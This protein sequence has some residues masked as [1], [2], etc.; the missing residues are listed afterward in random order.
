MGKGYIFTTTQRRF[1]RVALLLIALL[2]APGMGWGQTLS[3]YTFSASSGTFSALG[4]GSTQLTGGDDEVSNS[5]PIGFTF[6]YCGVDYTSVSASTNGWMTFGQNITD[7]A[8]NN[9]LASRGTRPVIA[10]LWDDLDMTSGTMNSA[11]TGVYPNRVFTLEWYGAEWNWKANSQVISFQVKLYETSGKIEFIYKREAAAVNSGTASIGITNGS[12]GNGNFI[13]LQDVS[14][15]PT[16]STTN[17]IT[18]ISTRPVTGQV[19]AFVPPV[20]FSQGSG[21]PNVL[22]NWKT[23]GGLSPTSFTLPNQIF[24]VQPGH[25]MTTTAAGWSVSGANTKVQVQGGGV[26]TATSGAVTLSGNTTFQLDANATYNHNVASDAIWSGTEVLDAASTVVYGASGAQNVAALNYGNLTI[27]G[28]G[29]KTMQGSVTVNGTLNLSNGSISLGSGTN[30]LTI[31]DGATL[32]GSFDSNHMVICDG[33]GSL[34]KQ[35]NSAADFVMV[36]PVGTGAYYTPY[37]ITSLTATATATSSVAVRAVASK[38]TGANDTDLTKYWAVAT[39]GL[40]GIAANV[41]MAYNNSEVGAGGDQA[42][43]IP[44]YYNGTT[45][46]VPTTASGPGAN[47]M[48]VTGAT[49]LTG[50]WTAREQPKYTTYY[51]YQSGDWNVATTWTTDPSGTLS[52]APAIPTPNDRVVILNG[53]TVATTENN[54]N[55]LSVQVNEGGTLDLGNFTTQSFTVVRGQGLVRLSNS[56]FP[57]A[58]WSSFV[59]AGGGTVE[60]YNSADFNFGQLIY[61]NLILNLSANTN[62]ATLVGNMTVN[63]NLTV[64]RGKLQINSN[65]STTSRNLTVMGNVYVSANGSIGIGTGNAKHRIEV[66]GNFTNDGVVRFTNQAAPQYTATPANGRSDVVFNNATADQSLLCNGQSDFY[67][68]EIDKG[69]D[70][71]YVLNIDASASANFKLFGRNDQ[72]HYL[73]SETPPNLPN[74]NALGLLAGTVRLGNNVLIPCLGTDNWDGDHGVY[75]IDEDARLWLDGATVIWNANNQN[76]TPVVYGTLRISEN[77]YFDIKNGTNGLVMR[78]TG[79]LSV[80]GGQLDITSLRV[81]SQDGLGA[82]RGAYY[83]TGGTVNVTGGKTDFAASFMLPYSAMAF[84]MSGGTI[85]IL[86]PSSA[87]G[88]GRNFSLIIGANPSNINVTGGTIN[89]TTPTGGQGNINSSAP[90]WDLNIQGAGTAY[91][92]DYLQNGSLPYV[93]AITAPSLIVL[94]NLSLNGSSTLNTNSKDVLIGGDFLL[95]TGTYYLSGSNTTTFNGLSGQRFTNLGTVGTGGNGLYNLTVAGKSNLDIYSNNL[96]VRNNLT[97]DSGCFLNDVGHTIS[98]NGNVTNSGTHTSQAS[99]AILLNGTANQIVGGDGNGIFGNLNLNNGAGAKLTANQSVEGNL[100]L[101]AGVLDIGSYNLKLGSASNVYDALTGTTTASFG[102]AK[103]IKLAGLQSD[104]GVTKAYS[105]TANFLYPIG[106]ASDYTPANIRIGTAPAAWGAVTVRPVAQIQPF[107]TSTNALTYYWKVTSSGFGGLQPSS[108]THSYQ[109]VDADATNGVEASYIPAA[110]RPY[111]W[112]PINDPSKVVDNTNTINFSGISYVDGDYTAGEPN[113]FMPVKVFYSRVDEGEW[114]NSDTWSTD[115]VGGA[116]VATGSVEGVNI[117]GPNNPVVIGDATHNH[118]VT[119]PVGYKT[120]TTGGLQIS[121]GSTL[122]LTTTTGHNFGAIPDSKVLGTGTL[123][124]SSSAATAEFPGG[125]FGNFLSSGGGTVEYYSTSTLGSSF[126]LPTTYVSAGTTVNIA[127]YNNLVT[128]PAG[129]NTVTL[130]N[131]E[132]LVYGTYSAGGA[133]VSQLNSTATSR[134]LTVNTLLEVKASG[135][136]R[137]VNGGVQNVVANGNVVVDGTFDVNNGGSA[138]N[139]MTIQGNLTNNGTFDMYKS[140]T[141]LCDVTFTGDTDKEIN[142]TGT[143]TNFN[144][145][146]VNKGTSRN[147]LLE[148]K[149]AALSLNTSLPTALTLTSGTFRLTSP[150]T[151][152]LTNSGSFTIPISGCL[153]ANGG[154]I[155]IGGTAADDATDLKLDGRLEVLAGAVNIGTLGNNLNNDIEYS[156]GGTPEIIVGGT[157]KLFVNG[158]IRRVTTINTGSLNYSQSGSSEVTIAGRNANNSRSML[159]ILNAGSKFDMSGDSKL[160]ITG[161][162]NSSSSPDLYLAPENSTVTGGTVVLGSG[163]SAANSTFNIVTSVPLWNLTVDGTTSSKKGALNI[164]PLVLK[165]DLTINGNSS[166]MANGLDVTIAGGLINKNGNAATGVTTGGYQAGSLTQ[167]TTFNGTNQSISGNG[168]NLTNFANLIVAPSGTLTLNPNSN[169]R[170][171]GNLS[172]NSGVLSDG[173]NSITQIGNVYS[174]AKHVSP[175]GDG[176]ISF[177]GGQPQV[178]SGNGAAIFGNVI[179]NNSLGLVIRDNFGIDGKL[180]F[181]TGSIYLDDYLLTLGKD[182]TIAGT[183]DSSRMIILN[184]VI[185]DAGVKK[186]FNAGASTFT[187]PFGVAG[188]YTPATYSF[189]TNANSAGELTVKPVNYVHPAALAPEGDQLKYYWNVA[190]KNFSSAYSVTQAYSYKASDVLGNEAQYKVGRYLNG[191]WIEENGVA[192]NASVSSALHTINLTNVGYLDGEYTAGLKENFWNKKTLYSIKTNA[193]WFEKGTWSYSPTGTTSCD[194]IPDGNPVVIKAEHRVYLGSNEAKAFSVDIQGTLDVGL[195]VYHSIG[196][197]TGGGKLVLTSTNDGIFVF[198]GGN[199]D[200]FTSTAGST[201]EFTGNNE[202]TLPLKP[203]NN[204]KPYQNVIFSGTGKKLI[205]AE[206]L[207]V[208]GNLTIN[209]G[210]TLSNELFNRTITALG[211]WIDNNTSVTGGFIPGKGLVNFNGTTAQTLTVANG[212]TTEQFYN[213]KIDNAAGLTIAGSGK[214]AVANLLYLTKGNITTSTTNLLSITNTSSSAVVGGSSSSFVN[215]PLQKKMNAGGSFA[216]PVGDASDSRIGRVVL[217]EVSVS[218]YYTSQY[219]KQDTKAA[220]YDPEARTAPV[221]KVSTNEYWKV[222]GPGGAAGNVTLRWDDASGIIPPTAGSRSKL[223]VVEW[224][225]S[226]WVNRGNVVTDGGQTSGTIKTSPTTS[227]DGNHIMTIGVES[228]PTATITGGTT[229]ICNDGSTTSI[230]IALTGTGPWTIKYKINGGNETTVANIATS[231]YSLVVSNALPVLASGG[232]SNYVF[233]ISY[234]QDNTGSTGV[235]D[236]TT[237]ATITLKPSPTPAITG[238]TTTPTGSVVAYSTASSGNTYSWTITGGTPTSATTN[239][240]NVTWGAG[241]T[242]TLKLTETINGCSVTTPE[243]KVSITDIPEPKVSG[244]SSVCLNSVNTYSTPMVGTHTYT[245]SVVGGTYTNG[246]TSNVINV[247][248][249]TADNTGNNSVTVNEKG[250]SIVPNTLVVTVN[251]LPSAINTVSDPSVC[252]G[253]SGN[254][255]V[256]AAAPGIDYQLRLSDN[257]NVGN[258]VSSGPGGDTNLPFTAGTSNVTYNVWATN[259]Y[260]CSVELTDKGNVTVN[261]PPTVTIEQVSKPTDASPY[262]A[263]AGGTINVQVKESGYSYSWS[264][265][266]ASYNLTDADKQIFGVTAPANNTLFPDAASGTLKTPTVSVKVTDANGCSSTATQMLN[267]FRIPITGPP[268]HVGNNVSK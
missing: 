57:T 258:A 3:Q 155:N 267:F 201:I 219:Y 102:G 174:Q 21:D 93:P 240:V 182:A 146:T 176:G 159:E 148:V 63:G 47:P 168:A 203:G 252:A 8:S 156:S 238:L 51:S 233:T 1:T 121:S 253:A 234:V 172:L 62:V 22:G 259:E 228:L 143:T 83:Q 241:P 123:R 224:V 18:N 92:Q 185:S 196:H 114:G 157:G 164:Y 265:D 171:N 85:N 260:N 125:D 128:A 117:P 192:A 118:K 264:I 243:Y 70:Q 263:C 44:W 149:S 127:T 205:T 136:L 34:V 26:L 230:P 104:A 122:D 199:F 13:S 25:T 112:V 195:T 11:T 161:N 197:V 226:S 78:T 106:T 17:E 204:Y 162:F 244:N 166:F 214:A 115:S 35:G 231:P 145:I 84:K 200:V 246:A 30:N 97:L 255:V 218:G 59:S 4:A 67:R 69:F 248:W 152:G 56:A 202:A 223:R 110:Y 142:G 193:N 170:V 221:D 120:I 77:S 268:Y 137:F 208:L 135:T 178:V 189:A 188:K 119:V 211:N 76:F 100:R 237:S 207:K 167:T 87:T 173:G 105:T 144:T 175:S 256:A 154:T 99:G 27:E 6:R 42:N 227:L 140:S 101:A 126:V 187:Y 198:P 24:I 36:Y 250:S 52:V 80:E 40:S 254:V 58:D 33:T 220:G 5:I 20:F 38:A 191:V 2:L 257:S 103:M 72:Q 43:Y 15:S 19:Y 266:D 183:N 158:Q 39:S 111:S 74:L 65:T 98:V 53:R 138:L 217:S 23:M 48:A 9:G 163:V 14:A 242:G 222:I 209:S 50:Q 107:A 232:P 82:H 184:G 109:Y 68:I 134:T 132:V 90:F 55:V 247:T 41:R 88:R 131:S 73:P 215:G 81:S 12:T 71:T 181:T 160:T 186:I 133:G 141:R 229:S 64:T 212:T 236:F 153:S 213:L 235:S 108:V 94:H 61:N 239:S 130:P 151:L 245:W 91:L 29:T 124:I 16:T 177:E 147:T 28:G 165:G 206:D 45:W 139:K 31:A 54:Y 169:I 37:E 49:R 225:T 10:P 60:Y 261:N 249:T 7:A 180:T 79:L 46:S 75:N 150:I 116:A 210:A 86:A 129:G 194:C 262:S 113:A 96:I 89:I 66:K 190:V 32:S 216:F 179:V 251:P 95:N